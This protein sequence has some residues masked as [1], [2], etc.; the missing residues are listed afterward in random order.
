MVAWT[1]ENGYKKICGR[2][3]D[4]AQICAALHVLVH[5]LKACLVNDASKH[6]SLTWASAV[7]R[8]FAVSTAK[9]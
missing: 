3:D 6:A 5:D 9:L 7:H 8:R 1:K 2:S 4:I